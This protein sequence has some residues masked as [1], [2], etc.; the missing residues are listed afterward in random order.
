[1]LWYDG[2]LVEGPVPFDLTDRGLLLSDGVF[3]TALALDGRVVFEDAHVT[4]LVAAAATLGFSIDRARILEAMRA[5]ATIAPR[6]AIRT[7]LTRG[8]GPR[9][10]APPSEAHPL[11]FAS[12]APTSEALAFAPMRLYPTAIARNET[13]P[14]SRLK[15]LGYLDAV[16]AAGEARAAGF[17]EALF[18]NTQ[19]RIAC[20]G[21]GNLF[22]VIDGAL[23]T[24]PLEE[25]VL[26]GIVRGAILQ[27][28]PVRERPIAPADLARAEAVYVTNSLRLV[29]PVLAIGEDRLASADHANFATLREIITQAC[30]ADPQ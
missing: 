17:D 22:A 16:I 8:A 10:I 7:T 4:R 29:S 13:S 15:T 2:A 21:I 18:S 24:P 6:A 5:L 11:L 9:G 23:C 19:G 27:R 3:D 14:A 26:D 1:M 20:A 28:L 12:A 30:A 25:G